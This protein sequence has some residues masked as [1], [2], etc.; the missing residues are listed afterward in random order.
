M[1]TEMIY[2]T[3]EDMATK[4]LKDHKITEAPID[5]K[6]VAELIGLSVVEVPHDNDDLCGLLLKGDKKA[7]IGVNALHHSNRKRF[8]IAHEIGHYLLHKNENTFLDHH[9]NFDMVKFRKNSSPKTQEEREAN[10]FAAALLMPAKLLKKNFTSLQ[11]VM[12][13]SQEIIQLLAKKYAVSPDAM[14]YRLINLQLI[15]AHN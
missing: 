6:K 15:S 5:P 3:I 2:S 10:S 9:E 13:N 1:T 14:R 8:T 12:S 11:G 7:I 4:V